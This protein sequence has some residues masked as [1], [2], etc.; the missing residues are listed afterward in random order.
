M[1]A[2]LARRALTVSALPQPAGSLADVLALPRF[3]PE[4]QPSASQ[5]FPAFP[6]LATQD[7]SQRFSSVLS[8]IRCTFAPTPLA[9]TANRAVRSLNLC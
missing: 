6:V 5:T 7:P 2:L 1:G 9:S 8:T 4:Q 3:T